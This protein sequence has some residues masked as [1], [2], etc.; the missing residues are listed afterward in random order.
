MDGTT[1]PYQRWGNQLY[2][3]RCGKPLRNEEAYYSNDDP[4]REE[5]L[6]SNCYKRFEND[7]K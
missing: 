7:R 3:I 6:C 5:A 4:D 2:C 1:F